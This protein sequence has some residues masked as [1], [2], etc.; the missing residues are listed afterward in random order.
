M[1]S[2]VHG[3]QLKL[4]ASNSGYCKG[5]SI[6]QAPPTLKRRS[7]K[8]AAGTVC[9]F[10]PPGAMLGNVFAR[11]SILSPNLGASFEDKPKYRASGTW[12]SEDSVMLR[13]VKV[14]SS[15]EGHAMLKRLQSELNDGKGCQLRRESQ[16]LYSLCCQDVRA[17]FYEQRKELRVEVHCHDVDYEPAQIEE[18]MKRVDDLI[19]D[20]QA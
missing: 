2:T 7:S 15:G 20:A 11:M 10:L 9:F 17:S 18:N 1:A 5:A 14:R 16:S 4:K 12:K 8:V 3:S 13:R 6:Y 19:R